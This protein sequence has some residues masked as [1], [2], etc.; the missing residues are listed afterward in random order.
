MSLSD[1]LSVGGGELFD[2]SQASG[3]GNWMLTQGGRNSG[4]EWGGRR[5]IWSL[6]QAP[7]STVW[8]RGHSRLDIQSCESAV[9]SWSPGWQITFLCMIWP[10]NSTTNVDS[11]LSSRHHACFTSMMLFSPQNTYQEGVISPIYR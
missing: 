1:Q 6:K 11:L 3:V 5:Y 9:C 8:G 2:G 10:N 7:C 4:L